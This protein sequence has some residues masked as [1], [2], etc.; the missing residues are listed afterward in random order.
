MLPRSGDY[1]NNVALLSVFAFIF[2]IL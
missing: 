2:T 1:N